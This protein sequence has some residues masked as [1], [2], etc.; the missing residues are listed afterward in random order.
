M[1]AR[2]SERERERI[3]QNAKSKDGRRVVN[4]S[5]WSSPD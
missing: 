2:L 1:S 4:G 5:S 3:H